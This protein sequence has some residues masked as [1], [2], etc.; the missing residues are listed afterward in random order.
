M[1]V[2]FLLRYFTIGGL[3]RVV[4]NLANNLA[5]LGVNVEVVVMEK[6]KRNSL[7][8]EL[9]PEVKITFLNG[10]YT[11]K[12]KQIKRL[13]KN[14]I[15]HVHFGD[16]KIHP[17]VRFSIASN[18]KVITYHSCYTH[19]RNK[20]TNFID[21]LVTKN[22]SNI[23]AVSDAVK[24]FCIDEVGLDSKKIDV[25]KNAIEISTQNSLWEN[26]SSRVFKMI[27]L[28][29]LYP[30]K[31]HKYLLE[32]FA[33]V[34]SS[35]DISIQ[36]SIIGDGPEMADLHEYSRQLGLSATDI[37]WYGAVWQKELTNS[38]LKD[39]D[40]F[41]S[42]SKFEGL[43]LSVLEAISNGVPVLLSNIDS[44]K[45]FDINQTI[46]FFCLDEVVDFKNKM[47]E[48]IENYGKY[49]KECDGIYEKILIQ[50]NNDLFIDKHLNIYRNL[51]N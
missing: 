30:H 23:I 25:I 32:A 46:K 9:N 21:K 2:V 5:I 22:Y 42:A 35:V 34:K 12:L 39:A 45:E 28:S 3:E 50:Q 14:K 24:S 19:K 43:P 27:S 37:K 7:I 11:K 8:T 20:I 33:K 48:V 31:N 13:T 1:E 17:L 16:G 4:I 36:L 26:Q 18:H 38:I 41:V 15:T 6:G 10:N 49:K 44:H 40:L 51:I 29:S 47:I